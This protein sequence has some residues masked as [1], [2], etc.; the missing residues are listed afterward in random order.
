LEGEE[1]VGA[2][3][4]ADIFVLP[5]YSENFGVAV[6]EAMACGLPVIVSDQGGIHRELTAADAR[7]VVPC[8]KERL[9]QSILQLLGDAALHSRLSRNG[10]ALAKTF[11]V[12]A[13]TEQLVSL[14]REIIARKGAGN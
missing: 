12:D 4:D 1:K 13:V 8:E 9:T 3:R 5:S 14:Y 7:I 11:S 10:I 6:V 2:L